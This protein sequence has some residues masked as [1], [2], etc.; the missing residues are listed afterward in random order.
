MKT[1]PARPEAF[2]LLME[3]SAAFADIEENGMKID[4][5][6]LDRAIEW[7]GKRIRE[8]EADLRSDEIYKVWRKHYGDGA[9]LG[10]RQQ[11]GHVIFDLLKYPCKSFN[12]AGKP[13]TDEEAFEDIDLPFVKK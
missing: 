11:L 4:V 8:L 5:P 2:K 10:K 13:K 7:S 1:I 6:Y 9:D 3:G 12:K